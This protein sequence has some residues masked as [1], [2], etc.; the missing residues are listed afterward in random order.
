MLDMAALPALKW[1]AMQMAFATQGPA[2]VRGFKPGDR[3]AFSFTNDSGGP[4][5]VSIRKAGQ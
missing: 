1:P 4:R 3:I 2:Q 5:L